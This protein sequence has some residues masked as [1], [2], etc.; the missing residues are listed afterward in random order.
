VNKSQ[1]N[2][3]DGMAMDSFG[4]RSLSGQVSYNKY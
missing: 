1:L 2:L 4:S 3:R